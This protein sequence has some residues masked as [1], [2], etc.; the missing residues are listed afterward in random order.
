MVDHLRRAAALAVAVVVLLAG[1][2][3]AT[4]NSGCLDFVSGCSYT[5][6]SGIGWH[7]SA[8]E[9]AFFRTPTSVA[10]DSSGP[11]L[12]WSFVPACTTL[13]N[14]SMSAAVRN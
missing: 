8:E 14:R 2:A 6:S 4:S 5:T 7:Y 1:T 11:E 10:V 12:Q 9:E 13:V 3:Y